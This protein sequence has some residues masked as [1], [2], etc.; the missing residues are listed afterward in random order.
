MRTFFV[1]IAI[2]LCGCISA[3]PPSSEEQRA[4]DAWTSLCGSSESAIKPGMS[5]AQV[6]ETL[7]EKFYRGPK[8]DAGLGSGYLSWIGPTL[9]GGTVLYSSR[10][11]GGTPEL[12]QAGFPSGTKSWVGPNPEGGFAGKQK[13]FVTYVLEIDYDE[14]GIVTRCQI[15]KRNELG[16]FGLNP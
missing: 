4:I 13:N 6:H 12:Y 2:S 11:L 9:P 8:P 16:R 3:S 10:P 14:S 1:L 15:L 7:K 5:R